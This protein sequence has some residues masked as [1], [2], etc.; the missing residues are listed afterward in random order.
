M[1]VNFDTAYFLAWVVA[2]TFGIALHEFS[3]AFVAYR[4]GD[5]TPRVQGRVTLN[6]T[7]HHEPFGLLMAFLLSVTTLSGVAWGKPVPLNSY[8]VK[9]GR[10]GNLIVLL[11]GPLSNLLLAFLINLAA[12]PYI[13]SHS[14]NDFLARFLFD[15]VVVNILL[16]AFNL[17]IP[18]APLDGLGIW[19][20]LLPQ[21]WNKIFLPLE[22]YGPYILLVLIFIV[23]FFLQ[24]QLFSYIINP[25]RDAVLRLF[26][27]SI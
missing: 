19:R 5:M 3:Q 8:A 4:L 11:A 2:F 7:V 26:G 15:L 14:G 22:T 25:V 24:I 23:P 18:L 10:A 1:A 13:A 12:A 17:F 27:Y 9:G 6:P 21:Q 16:F 20:N